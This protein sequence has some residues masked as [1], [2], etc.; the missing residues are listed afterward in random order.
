MDLKRAINVETRRDQ[1]LDSKHLR[2]WGK[3][4]GYIDRVLKLAR[5]IDRVLKLAGYI[6]RVLKLARYIDRVLKGKV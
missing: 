2:K 3:L 5:Y 1:H 6:D 4:A